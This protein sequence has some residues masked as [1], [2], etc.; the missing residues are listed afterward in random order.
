MRRTQ[1]QRRRAAS[2]ET[3]RCHGG[4][5]AVTKTESWSSSDVNNTDVETESCHGGGVA[6]LSR[7][8]RADRATLHGHGDGGRE[9]SGVRGSG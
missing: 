3:E 1:M 4:A 5:E 8:Q 7:R 6:L 2:P 9:L